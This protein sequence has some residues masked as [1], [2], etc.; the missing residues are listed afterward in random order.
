[1]SIEAT[2]IPASAGTRQPSTSVSATATRGLKGTG[3]T[4]R[5]A[6]LKTQSTWVSRLDPSNE[7][8]ASSR[9]RTS[10]RSRSCHTG[11]RAISHIITDRVDVVVSWAASSRKIM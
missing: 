9:S 5:L 6:S 8:A 2:V 4:R 1:M 10:S 7:S 3:G 11:W